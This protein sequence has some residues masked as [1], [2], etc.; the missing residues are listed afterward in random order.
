MD[1]RLNQA[2]VPFLSAQTQKNKDATCQ[3]STK[4][5]GQL[6][7]S[8]QPNGVSHP[9]PPEKVNLDE[10]DEIPEISE[11]QDSSEDIVCIKDIKNSNGQGTQNNVPQNDEPIRNTLII[12]RNHRVSTDSNQP[13]IVIENQQQVSLGQLH[14]VQ[15]LSS[16]TTNGRPSNLIGQENA[17]NTNVQETLV[18]FCLMIQKVN[19]VNNTT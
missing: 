8:N 19:N 17:S 10:Y 1:F 9:K 12:R 16:N 14:L 13:Q 15:N 2:K 18:R 7:I 5:P 4:N 3:S 11:I 6:Q